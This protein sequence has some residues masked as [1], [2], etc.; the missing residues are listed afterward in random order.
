MVCLVR[1]KWLCL[2]GPRIGP[3]IISVPVS[4]VVICVLLW[5]VSRRRVASTVVL[6]ALGLP[7][8]MSQL[9]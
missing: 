9:S 4:T 7:L 8:R 1:T 6:S 3:T 5:S 2:L